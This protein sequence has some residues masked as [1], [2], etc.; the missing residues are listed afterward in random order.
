M[1]N[2][3]CL[4]CEYVLVLANKTFKGINKPKIN[5]DLKIRPGVWTKKHDMQ[6]GKYIKSSCH[7]YKKDEGL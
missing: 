2:I 6:Y 1:A 5:C 7:G 3:D 4:D